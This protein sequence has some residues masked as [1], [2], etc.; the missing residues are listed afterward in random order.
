MPR[1]IIDDSTIDSKSLAL[2]SSDAERL[3][4]RFVVMADDYG[5][6]DT[7]P[8][9]LRAR[10][11]PRLVDRITVADIERWLDELLSGD[12]PI[13]ELWTYDGRVYVHLCSFTKRQSVRAL[14]SKYPIAGSLERAQR[15]TA[16]KQ[17]HAPASRRKQ[18][19]S[20]VLGNGNECENENENEKTTGAPAPPTPK[21]TK[22]ATFT[23]P[24][25]D[26]DLAAFVAD[27][28]DYL[29]EIHET[30][31]TAE[32]FCD[33]YA[34]Q[35]WKLANGRS[36]T[37]WRACVRTWRRNRDEDDAKR[38]TERAY[39]GRPAVDP[40]VGAPAKTI[41]NRDDITKYG[42]EPHLHPRWD[43]Y[44]ADCT[45]K[46]KG[47]T[48]AWPRFESWLETRAGVTQ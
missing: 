2:V 44:V 32:H 1:R 30:R 11:F 14:K 46:D 5:W 25:T 13:A 22:R 29:T 47:G 20:N 23:P 6:I 21:P 19:L 10:A 16:C 40:N 36:I 8:D 31:F 35:G 4:W 33:A 9:V 45:S 17:L 12:D 41:C 26:D 39:R 27:V 3:M 43:T 42:T 15:L 18:V 24:K 34:R 28:R 37:D 7:D 48:V 38:R